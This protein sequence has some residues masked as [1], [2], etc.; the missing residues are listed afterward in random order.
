MH[1]TGRAFEGLHQPDS[2]LAAYEVAANA[3]HRGLQ[4]Q[5]VSLAPTYLRLGE[6]YEGK[7]DRTKALEYYGRF[8]DLWKDADAELQ[9][10]VAEVRKRIAELAVKER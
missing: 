9:P 1:E 7:A 6:L 8:V 4:Y 10:R 2:A 3:I 5:Q